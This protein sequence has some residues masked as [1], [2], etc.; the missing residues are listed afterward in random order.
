M[1]HLDGCDANKSY[2]ALFHQKKEFPQ[3][4]NIYNN[5]FFSQLLLNGTVLHDTLNAL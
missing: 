2:N 1:H 4:N 3:Y 5:L